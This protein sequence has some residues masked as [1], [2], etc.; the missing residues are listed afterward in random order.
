MECCHINTFKAGGLFIRMK[1]MN[2]FLV[3]VVLLLGFACFAG[4]EVDGAN[5][6]LENDTVVDLPLDNFTGS[7]ETNESVVLNESDEDVGI[8]VGEFVV[9]VAVDDIMI[10]DVSVEEGESAFDVVVSY[11]S[12][13]VDRINAIHE[14]LVL[15]ILI[16][17]WVLLLFVYSAF[18]DTSSAKACFSKAFSL[19]R[20]ATIAHVNGNYAKAKRLYNKSYLLR[21]KGES[22]V[23]GGSNDNAI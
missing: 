20:K 3:G 17:L 18:Y 6:S 15:V 7:N 13:V 4:A 5:V 8:E 1:E 12:Y 16:V 14:N 2:L 19:H 9:D 22:K 23:S 10:E 21:E 11:V